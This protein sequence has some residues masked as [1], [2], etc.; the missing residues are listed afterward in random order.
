[1][2]RLPIV[3]FGEVGKYWKLNHQANQM[4]PILLNQ[5]QIK[6]IDYALYGDNSVTR[7]W[8]YAAWGHVCVY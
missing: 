2:K 1:M 6:D 3:K 4:L 5:R 8:L 7:V